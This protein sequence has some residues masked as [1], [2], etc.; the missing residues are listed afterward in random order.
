YSDSLILADSSFAK[1]LRATPNYIQG[2]VKRSQI[3]EKLDT[4]EPKQ[5]FALPH[6]Q[7]I[8]EV[9]EVDAVKNKRYLIEAYMY[10]AYYNVQI[11]KQND[12]LMYYDKVLALD[13]ENATAMENKKIIKGQ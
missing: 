3:A 7:K 11:G 2:Y 6:Y 13:P 12:A 5:Y 9:G 4:L 8:I 10:L 1:V